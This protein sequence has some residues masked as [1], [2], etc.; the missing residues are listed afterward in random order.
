MKLYKDMLTQNV[1]FE[2]EIDQT[3]LLIK[4]AE[5]VTI[6]TEP[7][8]LEYKKWCEQNNLEPKHEKNLRTFLKLIKERMQDNG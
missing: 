1:Y 8:T 2:K 3:D 7:T 5:T 6:I 4:R